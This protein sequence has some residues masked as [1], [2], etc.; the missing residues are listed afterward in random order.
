MGKIKWDLKNVGS[1]MVWNRLKSLR[2]EKNLTQLEVAKG[3]GLSLTWIAYA[4]K[5][6]DDNISDQAKQKIADFFQADVDDIFP[7]EMIGNQPK[8]GK[9]KRIQFFAEPEV[10][11]G[12]AF[13]IILKNVVRDLKL[14]EK[15]ESYYREVL[16]RMTLAEISQELFSPGMSTEAVK[17]VIEKFAKKY[18]VKFP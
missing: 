6:F 7:T 17:K 9:V 5:G 3:T 13:L 1:R 12:E 18:E 2:K 14:E 4:E 10:E 15:E 11:K 8:K 16:T